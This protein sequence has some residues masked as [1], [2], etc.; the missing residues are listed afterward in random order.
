MFVDGWGAGGRGM[1]ESAIQ[2]K[3]IDRYLEPNGNLDVCSLER[4]YEE[5]RL[6][7]CSQNLKI[8]PRSTPVRISMARGSTRNDSLRHVS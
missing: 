3:M 8:L 6:A 1:E 7:A 2:R 5:N 4:N